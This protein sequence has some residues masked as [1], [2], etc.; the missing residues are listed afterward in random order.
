[1]KTKQYQIKPVAIKTKTQIQHRQAKLVH[2]KDSGKPAI[3]IMF[4]YNKDDVNHIKTLSGRRLHNNGPRDKFWTCPLSIESIKSLQAWAFELDEG[5]QEFLSK[6]KIH[7]DNVEAI[8]VPR[9]K[10]DLYPF[11]KKGVGFIEAKNGRALI[12]DEM[13]LGK[14]A[15]ALAWLQLHPEKR[16]AIVIVPASLKLNWARECQMWLVGPNVQ[17]L[18]GTKPNEPIIGDIIIINYD[19]LPAWLGKLQAIKAQVLIIDECFPAGTKIA[20]PEGDKNIET[21]REGDQVHN[22]IGVGTVLKAG[23]R[24][25]KELINLR[26]SN[27]KQITV[28]PNHPFFTDVG[29]LPARN[30]KDRFLSTPSD[31]F[32]I[33]SKE[34]EV[35]G[36]VRVEEVEILELSSGKQFTESTVYNLKVSGHPSYYAEGFLVHNCHYI[37]NNKAKRTKA[38]KTLGKNIPHVIALSG[39]PIV[40]R[41]VEAYNALKLIDDTVIPN[42]WEY[43]QRYCGARHTGFGWDFTGATRTEELHE[44]L[45]STC[46]SYETI[47]YLQTGPKQ[48]GEVVENEIKEDVLSFNFKNGQIQWQPILSFSAR[49]IPNQT[50]RIVHEFGELHCTAD[51]RIWTKEKGYI[52][53]KEI[54]TDLSLLVLPTKENSEPPLNK[55]KCQILLNSMRCKTPNRIKR[56]RKENEIHQMGIKKNKISPQIL[57]K[58]RH[59]TSYKKHNYTR[60]ETSNILQ[61]L[62]CRKM[63]RKTPYQSYPC[64][65]EKSRR[66]TIREKS[67]SL[68]KRIEKFKRSW[69][70]KTW[71]VSK[72]GNKNKTKHSTKREMG[73]NWDSKKNAS[74]LENIKTRTKTTPETKL[75]RRIF[76]ISNTLNTNNRPLQKRRNIRALCRFSIPKN[77]ISYRNRRGNTQHKTTKS[78]GQ[79]ER[80][81]TI[82]SRVV[83][84]EVLESRDR[85][86]YRKDSKRDFVYDIQ[87]G[88][89]NNFF[90]NN[91]L[92]HNCMLRRLKKD[93]LKDLPDKTYSIVPI[94]INNRREYHKAESDFIDWI[95]QN[96]GEEAAKKASNAEALAKIEALKQL[97]VKGKMSNAL[98]WIRDFLEV[99]GKLIVFATHKMTIDILMDEF[100]DVAVKIDGSTSQQA[101]QDAVDKFQTD[102]SCRLFIGNIKAAGVGISLT[103]ASNVAFLELPWT[104]GELEQATDRCHRIGQKNAVNVYYLLAQETIE[105]TIA[106]ILDKKRKVL[107]KVLDG[108]E[109]EENTTFNELLKTYT[110]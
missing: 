2:Y 99:D 39:T 34:N 83:S 10:M 70:T 109:T 33:M 6:S 51:H 105:E 41:P 61:H 42:F 1:M 21:I 93:V 102:D 108:K 18:S 29:W 15:Q 107:D 77:K 38:V 12:A 50:I 67:N 98:E 13:G 56:C 91:C 46:L 58:L 31:V 66:T 75:A 48:I 97:A 23:K 62:L 64:K 53:A 17:R 24:K 22:A 94:E 55:N 7:A 101:R 40:N 103:T 30:C 69:K 72:Q 43:A 90:A 9:L 59:R 32:S 88:K 73:K 89:N 87:V 28:T 4:P 14:T 85:P 57:Q 110:S 20:T 81:E 5:L 45:T 95:R 71:A 74:E 35:P 11:Q 78:K 3:K 54:T 47:I 27:N 92:V 36:T 16:P 19:I 80:K 104:P 106:Y 26:L 63:E 52:R 49:P 100:K 84:L 8:D 82:E 44:K 79:M 25:A 68:R 60:L 76:G 37:K 96:K 86:K 65:M